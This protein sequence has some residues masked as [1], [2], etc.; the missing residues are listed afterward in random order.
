M[1]ELLLTAKAWWLDAAAGPDLLFTVRIFSG[2]LNGVAFLIALWNAVH[3]NELEGTWDRATCRRFQVLTWLR[4]AALLGVALYFM[5]AAFFEVERTSSPH[6]LLV[7]NGVFGF[8]A[9]V[10]LLDMAAWR[11][12]YILKRAVTGKEIK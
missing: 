10:T 2:G 11:M 4:A 7:G 1:P 5:A 8:L 6:R 3:G 9:A 12:H